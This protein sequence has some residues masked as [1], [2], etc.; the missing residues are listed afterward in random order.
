[1]AV[2]ASTSPNPSQTSAELVVDR[3]LSEILLSKLVNIQAMNHFRIMM[4][5][6]KGWGQ[7]YVG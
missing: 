5:V 3:L 7:P 6:F 1:V 4:K 2:L